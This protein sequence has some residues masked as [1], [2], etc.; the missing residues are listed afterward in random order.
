MNTIILIVIA[1]ILIVIAFILNNIRVFLKFKTSL[2]IERNIS[3]KE[4]DKH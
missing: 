4:L 1:I 2:L 3:Q